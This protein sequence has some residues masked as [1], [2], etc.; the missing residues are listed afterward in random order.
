MASQNRK[1]KVLDIETKYKLISEVER[2][3]KKKQDIANDFGIKQN[4]LSGIMK[5]RDSIIAAYE[6]SS[7]SP[8]RKRMRLATHNHVEEALYEWFKATRSHPLYIAPIAYFSG[9]VNTF[10]YFRSKNANFGFSDIRM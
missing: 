2:G 7:F 4:S 5:K 1:R 10:S 8:K 3:I 6:T 9:T